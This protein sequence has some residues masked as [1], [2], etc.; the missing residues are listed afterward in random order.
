IGGGAC[1][2]VAVGASALCFLV[3]ALLGPSAFQP[4]LSGAPGEPPYALDTDPSP[5]LVTGLVAAG[6]VLGAGGLGAC[7]AAARRGWTVRPLPLVWTGLAVAVAFAFLPPVGSSDHLNYASYGRMAV[8]GHDP[9]VTTAA[10]VPDDPVIGA[11]EEWRTTPSVYGPITTAGQAFASWIG[12][13]SVKLT[14]FALSAVNAAAFALTAWIL[15]KTSRT[16]ARRLRTALLWTCNPLLLYHLISGG[17]NDVLAIAPM[18]AALAVFGGRAHGWGRAL[19]AGALTG[20]GAAIK[21]P[22]ALVGGGPAWSLLRDREARLRLVALFGGAG[23][24]TAAAY[25]LAG[26]HALDQINQASDMVSFATPW[27]LL[28]DALG[29]GTD[30]GLIKLGV[31]LLALVLFALLVRALPGDDDAE[32]ARVS[33]A[34]VLAW[35]LAA[36]YELPWYDGFGWALLALLPWTRIDWI[37]LAHTTALTFA[38]LPARAPELTGMPDDLSWLFTIVRPTVVPWTLLAVLAALVFLCLRSDRPPATAAPPR[39]S[40]AS[41]G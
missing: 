38:Y 6:I 9:Y 31:L 4:A 33:T 14:V 30:R 1:G 41:R 21:L 2:L 10:D 22:A 7:I 23:A 18:V 35:L 15:Y 16:R 28:D 27:H 13:D 37:M 29:R 32:H 26:P 3:T 36:P 40:A 39:A 5:Y 19:A 8:T 20:A 11:P 17:H 12:G 24:V 34:L 25:A